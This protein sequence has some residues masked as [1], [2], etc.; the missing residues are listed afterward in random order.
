MSRKMTCLSL[1]V[2]IAGSLLL[3]GSLHAAPPSVRILTE[4]RAQPVPARS[5]KPGPRMLTE[6]RA[7][8]PRTRVGTTLSELTRA[9]RRN[10]PPLVNSGSVQHRLPTIDPAVTSLGVTMIGKLSD[11]EAI[12]RIGG[13]VKNIGNRDFRS[14][15]GQQSV[16][17]A[18]RFPGSGIPEVLE[19]FDF[20]PLGAGQLRN[21]CQRM[22]WEISQEFPPSVELAITYHADIRTDGN[23]QNDD[24]DSSNNYSEISGWQITAAVR[25]YLASF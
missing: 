23:P 1:S 5:V 17:L 7:Q 3:A 15:R 13:T 6:R 8:P 14:G 4:R 24:W 25:E 2:L 12:I 21:A 18:K 9:Q 22:N 20:A 11:T 10:T 19:H 16:V